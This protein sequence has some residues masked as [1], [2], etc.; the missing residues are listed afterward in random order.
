MHP[1]H[2]GSTNIVLQRRRPDIEDQTVL[3]GAW[4][5]SRWADRLPC[6]RRICLR[7]SG[8]VLECVANTA[9]RLRLARRHE[10][11]L[12]AGGRTVGNA[13]EDVDAVVELAA[14]IA[15]AGGGD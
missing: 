1:H 12:A 7:A 3:A 2:H 10:A 6:G 8:A 15:E 5:F 11:I 9:P 13:F 4:R 14:Y